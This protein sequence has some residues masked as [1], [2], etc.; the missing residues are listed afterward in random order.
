LVEHT[1]YQTGN[2]S[3]RLYIGY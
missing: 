3:V 1:L 2:L